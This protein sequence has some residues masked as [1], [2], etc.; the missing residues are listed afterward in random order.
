MRLA[1][2]GYWYLD[3]RSGQGELKAKAIGIEWS[4][5][6]AAVI[7]IK[8]HTWSAGSQPLKLLR[9]ERRILLPLFRVRVSCWRRGNTAGLSRR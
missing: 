5:P 3:G 1:E 9:K 8:E 7:E 4:A 6:P 2:E